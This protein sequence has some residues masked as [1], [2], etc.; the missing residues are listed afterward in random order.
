MFSFK[1]LHLHVCSRCLGL[2]PALAVGA[3]LRARDLSLSPELDLV[4]RLLL[5]AFGALLW[6]LEHAR[7]ATFKPW[8]RLGSGI[9]IGVGLGWVLLLHFQHPWPRE[10]LELVAAFCAL[11]LLGFALRTYRNIGELELQEGALEINLPELDEKRATRPENEVDPD[12]D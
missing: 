7:L 6:A 4:L 1:Q 5:P 11:L 2:Y 12:A 9:M 3:V 8:T 10:L